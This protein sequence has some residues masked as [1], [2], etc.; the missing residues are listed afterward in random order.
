MIRSIGADLEGTGTVVCTA[1]MI[2]AVAL[3]TDGTNAGTWV[4]RKD[5]STGEIIFALSCKEGMFVTMELLASDTVY[6][7]VTGT[8]AKLQLF[9]YVV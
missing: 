8:G 4:L 1:G 3:T 6:Y 9:D 5:S 2:G 7:S